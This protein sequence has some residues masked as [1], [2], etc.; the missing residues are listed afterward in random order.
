MSHFTVLVIGDNP[1]EQLAP[2]HEYECTGRRDQYVI[3]VDITED[4]L[5][6]FGPNEDGQS[7]EGFIDDN[8]GYEVLDHDEELT[9]DHDYGYARRMEDGSIRVFKV[10]NPNAQWD[11]YEMGGRWTGFFPLTQFAQIAQHGKVGSPGLMTKAAEKGTAD[12]AVKSAID[13]EAGMD[14]AGKEAGARWDKVYEIL[15][16]YLDWETWDSVLDKNKENPDSAREIYHSQEAI[17]KMAA[18]KFNFGFFADYDQYLTTRE[19]YVNKA[20]RS[21]FATFALVEDS[22]WYQQGDMGWWGI[23]TPEMPEAEWEDFVYQKIQKASDETIFTLID[24]HI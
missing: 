15:G 8:Y 9:S 14:A 1:E 5:E 10:T 6:E 20:R 17:A 19:D 24:C 11:W 3:E 2:Y 4:V 13:F 21:R 22:K 16:E 18:S 12:Q 7:F 23:S